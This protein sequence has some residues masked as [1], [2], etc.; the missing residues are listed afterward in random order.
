MSS[1]WAARLANARK[2]RYTV[3]LAFAAR[4]GCVNKVPRIAIVGGGLAGLAA[5][6]DFWVAS[7]PAT[8][9]RGYG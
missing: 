4:D 1:L 8:S 6:I 7:A 3:A 5:A 2:L 9:G